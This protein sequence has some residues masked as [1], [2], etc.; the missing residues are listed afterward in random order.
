[1]KQK[2]RALLGQIP[3]ARR[4]E[5]IASLSAADIEVLL[6][7]WP[8]WA[9]KK[10]LLP[11]GDW[12]AWLLMAGRGFGKNRTGA[13][14]V[15]MLAAGG[16]A[17]QVGL[18]GDTAYDVRHVIVEGA[19]GVLAVSPPWQRPEWSPSQR[20]LVWPNGMVARCYSADDPEQLRGPEFDH[21]W[22]DEIG[23]WRYRVAWD[24]VML[25]L[26]SGPM[27]RALA[28][29]TPRPL[30]WLGEIAAAP[31]T[32]L[33]QGSSYENRAN[34]AALGILLLAGGLV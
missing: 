6:Y 2:W 1:L 7:D 33:V 11:A 5:F 8:L 34:L 26:R 30:R 3:K 32:V 13:E 19:A 4:S 21:V 14:W 17:A 18:V 27:P 28:T 9:R 29:T 31:D 22:A 20:R 23:K 25:G 15:G 24:N 10:Q 16:A 12:R